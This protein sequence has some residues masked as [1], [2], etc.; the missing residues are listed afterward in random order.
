MDIL[1]YRSTIKCVHMCVQ[2]C[3]EVGMYFTI[4]MY[5]GSSNQSAAGNNR[6]SDYTKS[7]PWHGCLYTAVE[8]VN[9]I[10]QIEENTLVD[11]EMWEWKDKYRA[12]TDSWIMKTMSSFSRQPVRDIS[13]GKTFELLYSSRRNIHI[14]HKTNKGELL[15]QKFLVFD[16]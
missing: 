1:F 14:S 3:I 9:N 4:N 11:K 13:T 12:V 7:Y 15:P 6:R 8:H 2:K 5:R 16:A 10:Y